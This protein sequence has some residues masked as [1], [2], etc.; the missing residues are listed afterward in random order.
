MAKNSN[1]KAIIKQLALQAKQRLKNSDYGTREENLERKRIQNRR[2]NLSLLS[3]LE[4]KKP[5]ITIKI[6]NDTVDDENF[7]NRVYAM[8][9]EN[10]DLLNPMANLID[11]TAF[12][13]FSETEQEKYILD[14]SER[15]TKARASYFEHYSNC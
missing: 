1:A 6:I 2:N 15:Y 14:L 3:G 10:E 9:H 8:L 7:R 12:D 5:E 11:Q 13:S 4:C